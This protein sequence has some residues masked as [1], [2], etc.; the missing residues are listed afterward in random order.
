[1]PFTIIADVR[2]VQIINL[3]NT[4]R[5]T[6]S[7]AWARRKEGAERVQVYDA[8][9]A[10]VSATALT[11]AVRLE[12]GEAGQK[13]VEEALGDLSWLDEALAG[14]EELANL[15]RADGIFPNPQ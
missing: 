14:D 9:S 3:K 13:A 4:A 5:D 6:L 2:G 1:M 8:S 12:I 10:F 11:H 15:P 7:L